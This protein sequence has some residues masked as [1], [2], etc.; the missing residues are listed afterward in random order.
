M[1]S[2]VE[3]RGEG[4]GALWLSGGTG[5]VVDD[6]GLGEVA[7]PWVQPARARTARAL[8]LRTVVV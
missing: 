4:A 1:A 2:A 8:R 7:L 3:D 6:I 5:T